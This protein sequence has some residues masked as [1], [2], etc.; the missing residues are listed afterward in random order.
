M[1]VLARSGIVST[2]VEGVDTAEIRKIFAKELEGGYEY[3]FAISLG[4]HKEPEDY[5]CGLS[6]AR[7]AQED[8]IT[9]S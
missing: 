3:R 7:L 9:T 1:H 8:I 5:N 6:K 4:Y 2:P